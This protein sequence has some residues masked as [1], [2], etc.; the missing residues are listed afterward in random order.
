MSLFIHT[1]AP[2]LI[3]QRASPSPSTPPPACEEAMST[4][5]VLL[6]GVACIISIKYMAAAYHFVRSQFNL[7]KGVLGP[8]FQP[9]TRR[10]KKRGLPEP[11][12]LIAKRVFFYVATLCY[13]R[14]SGPAVESGSRK[15]AAPV[16]DE[17]F[18]GFDVLLTNHRV[19]TILFQ[20]RFKA[21]P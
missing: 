2:K 13:E 15:E 16:L 6:N 10:G 7:A 4:R 20:V 9:I 14:R 8:P 3:L 18:M 21:T 12:R 17:F 11:S 19:L 5:A 1:P